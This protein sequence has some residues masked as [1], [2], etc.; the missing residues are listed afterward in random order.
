[1]LDQKAGQEGRGIDH[2]VLLRDLVQGSG[3][4]VKATTKTVGDTG[5][6]LGRYDKLRPD[7][8]LERNE[9]FDWKGFN[10]ASVSIEST[11]YRSRPSSIVGTIVNE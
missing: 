4:D 1:V 11:D 7:V 6:Q 2:P 9:A 5:P 8:L 3:R 10:G